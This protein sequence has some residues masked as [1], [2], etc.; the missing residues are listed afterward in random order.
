MTIEPLRDSFIVH[1][2]SCDKC[3]EV[4]MSIKVFSNFSNSF[5]LDAL[6]RA[7]KFNNWKTYKDKSGKRSHKCPACQ[8]SK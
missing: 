6:A 3:L 7:I 1:C 2:D 4:D 5:K 8:E